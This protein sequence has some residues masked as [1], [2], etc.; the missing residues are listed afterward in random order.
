MKNILLIGDSIRKGYDSFV[1]K[2]LEGRAN[3]FFS[4]ENARFAQYTL[5]YLGIWKEDMKLT[6]D[7]DVVHWNCGL[8]DVLH[9][10]IGV[11]VNDGETEGT[12]VPIF[13]GADG[14]TYEKDP[15][16]P[17]EFYA[18][19]IKRIHG[20]IRQLY[21]KAAVIFAT[22]TPAVPEYATWG[23]YR[24][25]AE[26]EQFNQIARDVLPPL[27]SRINELGRFAAEHCRD[28]HA[29]W[30]HYTEEGYS[31]LADEIVSMLDAEGLL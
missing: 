17:P 4:E 9:Q 22:T 8:W 13:H 19:L 10:G 3:V 1:Q 7:I 30:V 25:N 6:A 5:R 28:L 24:P 21:P 31:L 16:T 2:K 12:P 11:S 18:Y 26:I 23:A 27:G 20:T 15:L 29:D 14:Q